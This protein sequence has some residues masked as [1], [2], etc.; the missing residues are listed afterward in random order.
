M[1]SFVKVSSALMNG[2]HA[3]DSFAKMC[4]KDEG[5][6]CFLYGLP[7]CMLYPLTVSLLKNQIKPNSSPLYKKKKKQHTNMDT[8]VLNISSL[9]KAFQN[10]PVVSN[11]VLNFTWSL[12]AL[13]NC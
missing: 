8:V 6:V 4:V 10:E 11:V 2:T 5:T 7:L 3:E 12:T 9:L 13:C 1:A